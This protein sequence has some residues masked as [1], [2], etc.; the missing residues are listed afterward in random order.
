MV[1]SRSSVSRWNFQPLLRSITSLENMNPVPPTWQLEP[2]TILDVL[3]NRDSRMNHRAEPEE[4]QL[5]EKLT[6]FR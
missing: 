2:M 6:E 4:T 5:S 1:N 3:R